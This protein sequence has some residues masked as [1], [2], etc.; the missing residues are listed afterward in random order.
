MRRDSGLTLIETLTVLVALVVI[1]AA[2]IPLWR[3]RELRAHRQVAV[4]AL[5][6]I[7]AA[8][9]R[10]FAKHARYAELA[11]LGTGPAAANY[12]LEIEVGDDK[13]TYLATARVNRIAGNILDSRCPEMGVDQ[14]GRRFAH[15]ASG[16]DSTEDCWNNW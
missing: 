13:L 10:H 5:S 16:Q 8:Q 4:E 7:Q 2:A 9:D 1:A 3:T 11:Q 14:H 15:D 12:T 6:E